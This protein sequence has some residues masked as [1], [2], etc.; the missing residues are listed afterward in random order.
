[1]TYSTDLFQGERMAAAGLVLVTGATGFVGSGIVRALLADGYAVRALVRAS[2]PLANLAGLDIETVHGDI[3]DPD[4]VA[5]AIVGLRYVVHAAADYR[6]WAP[7]A[8]EL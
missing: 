8:N 6:L 5:R 4:A 3:C 7:D 2:S 1:M